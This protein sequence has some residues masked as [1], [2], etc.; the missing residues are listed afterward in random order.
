MLFRSGCDEA[1]LEAVMQAKFEP[2]LQRGE[3]VRVQYSIPVIFRL[4]DSDF[5]GSNNIPTIKQIDHL[6]LGDN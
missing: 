3:P 6:A 4:D 5:T 1:A 2:G